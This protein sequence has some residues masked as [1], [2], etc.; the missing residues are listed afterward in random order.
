MML[1]VQIHLLEV[2]M[3]NFGVLAIIIKG[4]NTLGMQLFKQLWY[5]S[6]NNYDV[7]RTLFE[8]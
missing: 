5:I 7:E 1:S 3:H 6:Y 2:G 8:S 4:T